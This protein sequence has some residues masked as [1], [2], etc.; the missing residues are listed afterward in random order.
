MKMVS[1]KAVAAIFI[2]GVLIVPFSKPVFSQNAPKQQTNVNDEQLKSFAKVYVQVEKI[3]QAYEPRVKQAP[4]PDEGKQ[5]QQEAQAK[6]QEVLTKEGVSEENYTQI[7]EMARADDSLRKKV[8]Q[9]IVE[10][11]NKS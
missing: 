11:R 3:R 7:I 5:I 1:L 9:M 6:F 2:A 8:L 10:E 4:G